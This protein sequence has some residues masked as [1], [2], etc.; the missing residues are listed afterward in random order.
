MQQRLRGPPAATAS[1]TLR[2]GNAPVSHAFTQPPTPTGSRKLEALRVERFARNPKSL[3]AWLALSSSW[4][5][6]I[7]AKNTENTKMENSLQRCALTPDWCGHKTA[8]LSFFAIFVFFAVNQLLHLGSF[9]SSF[10]PGGNGT[11]GSHFPDHDS[12]APFLSD[13]FRCRV[14]LFPC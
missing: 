5:E 12:L 1:Q 3:E 4:K 2:T 10:T 11:V 9:V 7:T 14:A 13:F 6:Q 8:Q